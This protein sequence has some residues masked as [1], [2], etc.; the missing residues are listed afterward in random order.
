MK[1]TFYL[2]VVFAVNCL[3]LQICTLASYAG[4]LPPDGWRYP[5]EADFAGGWLAFRDEFPEPYHVRGDFNGNGFEDDAW[6][7]INR[8][9]S[10]WGLFV[11][12]G[13][14]DMCCF[15]IQ[16]LDSPSTAYT[17]MGLD[18]VPPGIYKTACGKGYRECAPDEPEEVELIRPAINVFSYEGASTL[19]Y[20]DDKSGKFKSVA[21][22]E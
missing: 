8:D 10:G 7:M 18:L 19:Y 20:W 1:K 13:K 6:I 2:F 14:K 12:M 21:V 5:G 17:E 16:L 11:I 22:S 4:Q 3:S 9:N 15:A